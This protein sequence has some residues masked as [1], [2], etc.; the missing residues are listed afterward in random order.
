M[1][2]LSNDTFEYFL[3]FPMLLQAVKGFIQVNV[4]FFLFLC[5]WFFSMLVEIIVTQVCSLRRLESL[6]GFEY[7]MVVIVYGSHWLIAIDGSHI[8]LR[9]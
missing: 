3:Q 8:G 2:G 1:I 6:Q 4:S 7:Y 9:F 5:C